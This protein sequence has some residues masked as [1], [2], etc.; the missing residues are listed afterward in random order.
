MTK[1]L[2]WGFMWKV[3]IKFLQ[4]PAEASVCQRPFSRLIFHDFLSSGPRTLS[5]VSMQISIRVKF[6]WKSSIVI[7]RFEMLQGNNNY[8]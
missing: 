4:P 8:V 7:L 5:G 3:S 6:A 2:I 1:Y